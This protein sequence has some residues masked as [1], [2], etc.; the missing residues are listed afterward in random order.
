MV[1]SD[2]NIAN[3]IDGNVWKLLCQWTITY[4]HNNIYHAL[5]Y[6]LIFA[7]LRQ[8]QELAQRNVFQKAKLASF[9][10]D[11]FV[12]FPTNKSGKI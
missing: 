7:V 10:I 5:F 9:I 3:F 2:E 6:R 4:A 11:S 1:E 12:E 8:Q